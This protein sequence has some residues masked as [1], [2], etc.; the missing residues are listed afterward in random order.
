MTDLNKMKIFEKLSINEVTQFLI[1]L[2]PPS[3]T[4]HLFL[5]TEV[6]VPSRQNPL[7]LSL[8]LKCQ[9]WTI[10]YLE[11]NTRNDGARGGVQHQELDVF[12]SVHLQL[13]KVSFLF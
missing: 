9:L 13:L 4:C 7:P 11:V 5:N 8:R 3:P 2:N 10:P 12:S 6:C 1:G